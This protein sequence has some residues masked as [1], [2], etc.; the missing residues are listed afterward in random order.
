MAML[1]ESQLICIYE[2]YRKEA[3]QARRSRLEQNRINFDIYNMRQDYSDKRK[4][5]SREFLPKQ[6]MAVE[7]IANFMQQGLVDMGDWF[8]VYAAPGVNEDAMRVKPS[9]VEKILARSLEKA[10]FMMRVGD[11]VKLGLLG[12]LMIAKVHGRYCPKYRYKVEGR[13]KNGSYQKKLVKITDKKWELRID[14]I[15]QEDFL[16]DPQGRGLYY[17]QDVW[18]DWYEAMQMAQGPNAVYDKKVLE[19]LKGTGSQETPS[20][21]FGRSRETGQNPTNPGNRNMIKLTE[22]W[23]NFIDE[24]GEL[25]YENCVATIANDRYVVQKPTENPLWHGEHPFVACPV[26]TVHGSVWGKALMDAPTMLNIAQNEMFNL[27]LDGG[28]MAVHGIKQLYEHWL[29]DPSQVQDGIAPGETLRVTAA[30]PPGAKV[31]ERVDTSTI[32]QDGILVFNLLNQ[33]FNTAAITNDFRMGVQ[34]FRQVKATEIVESSQAITGM[35]S[36]FVKHVERH[37]IVPILQKSWATIAQH[38]HEMDFDELAAVI[39][40]RR[41]REIQAM[42]PEELFAETVQGCRFEVFGISAQ[43]N[44]QQ[45]F[46]K[47]QAMLQTIASAPILMEEFARKYD[48]SKLLGEIMKSLDINTAKIEA[49]QE[50]EPQT[51]P[52]P[53]IPSQAPDMQSQIPQAGAAGNQSD[54]SMASIPQPD[55]PASRATPATG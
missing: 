44:K 17:M 52:L 13:S 6:A 42:G 31:L 32:P 10:Q 33:E 1:D 40:E 12:S 8:R 54:L 47:L 20:R 22:I 51:Q 35:Y 36:G 29:E 14:L 11:A 18:L 27:I 48:F 53:I 39:G 25:I 2:A 26:I 3:D 19:K 46:T 38:I 50:I 23:G 9:E 49:D 43:L 5:Q 41:A 15:R 30:C 45:D 37:W 16:P 7:Q 24:T 4:G 28:M 55:F 21:E 34:P